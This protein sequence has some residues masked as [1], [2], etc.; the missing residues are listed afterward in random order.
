MSLQKTHPSPRALRFL[1]CSFLGA[2]QP[3]IL[4]CAY[5][6]II[7]I[8]MTKSTQTLRSITQKFNILF[9]LAYTFIWPHYTCFWPYQTHKVID[10][11]SV[12]LYINFLFSSHFSI[13]SLISVVYCYS[14]SLL[15][16]NLFFLCC[17]ISF[18]SSKIDSINVIIF[19][20]VPDLEEWTQMEKINLLW[21]MEPL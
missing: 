4:I 6:Y 9:L 18:T 21:R 13:S 20:T 1:S 5:N 7:I 15:V 10:H 3:H 14:H 17:F 11:L 16:P 12:F 19:F 2:F 8:I